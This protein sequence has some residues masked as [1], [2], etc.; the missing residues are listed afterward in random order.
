M[1]NRNILEIQEISP[2]VIKTTFHLIDN[3]SN[4]E[5]HRRGLTD[6][7]V[8]NTIFQRKY[9]QHK[10]GTWKI[11]FPRQHRSFE[12][13]DFAKVVQAALRYIYERDHP[14]EPDYFF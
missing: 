11:I 4:W 6:E 14:E 5:I 8:L 9:Y 2:E 7:K 3:T 1:S 10:P 13:Q 12:D